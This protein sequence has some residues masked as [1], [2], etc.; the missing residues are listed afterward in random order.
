MA[1]VIFFG[2]K[3]QGT[4]D[5]SS[6][7]CRTRVSLTLIFV[8]PSSNL[9]NSRTQPLPLYLLLAATISAYAMAKVMCY[10]LEIIVLLLG[11]TAS[12]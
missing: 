1:I 7:L 3:I 10:Y 8:L 9:S 6:R 4:Y 2:G 12:S 11:G 5:S